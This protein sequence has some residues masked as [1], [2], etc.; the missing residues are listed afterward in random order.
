MIV[1]FANLV[2]PAMRD[3]SGSV[4]YSGLDAF[5]RPSEVYLLGLNPGG[6]P[7]AQ[8]HETVERQIQGLLAQPANW[9]AYRDES[10]RG[11]APGTHGLQPRVLHLFDRLGLDPGQVPAS[12]VVFIRSAREADLNMEK[13]ALLDACW[14]LHQAVIDRLGVKV[15]ICFGGT[16]GRWARDA[17]DAHK[18]MDDFVEDNAR[19]WTSQ[20]HES[21][22][23]RRVV[24]LTHPSIAN[25]R[26]PATDPTPL[27]M[28][29]L[30][31]IR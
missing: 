21:S 13:A 25:W 19:R 18:L 11:R 10:W 29:T 4:F 5:N 7:V 17:L 20:A 27:V 31:R 1:D 8:A 24:T 30:G 15:V 16:A 12:N 6:D 26:A 9:S 22:S 14:P 2:P 3:R 23:G 28:R